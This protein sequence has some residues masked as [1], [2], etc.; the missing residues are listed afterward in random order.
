MARGR[1]SGTPLIHN[2][3]G[4]PRLPVRGDNPPKATRGH[5]HALSE[6]TNPHD[7]VWDIRDRSHCVRHSCSCGAKWDR[8]L[9]HKS[10]NEASL[11]ALAHDRSL[12]R[13]P[14]PAC[15]GRA[16]Q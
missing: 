13:L 3:S 7:T 2:P 10:R 6:I 8:Q 1:S 4:F 15:E 12:Q 9:H 11:V 5:I 14:V 16:G